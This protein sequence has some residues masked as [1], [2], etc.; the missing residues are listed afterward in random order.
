MK[1]NFNFVSI[2]SWIN[3][4]EK[5]DPTFGCIMMEPKEIK[6][7]EENH[8]AG[9]EEKDVYIKSNE[10]S[11][12]K[13]YQPHITILYGIHEDEIDPSVVIDMIEQK[14]KPITAEIS[15]IDV[16]ENDEYDVVKYNVTVTNELLKYREMFMNSFENTQTF[17]GYKPHITIAYV[18]PG[19]GKKYKRKLN[20]SFKVEFIKG[21]YSYHKKEKGKEDELIRRVVNLEEEKEKLDDSIINSKPLKTK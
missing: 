7:W 6:D 13:E 21:I 19:L 17:S 18:K 4:Q 12:G 5:E 3:E 14:M 9:I 15:E 2:S 10:D 1:N 20:K 16:F 11:Y 8:L